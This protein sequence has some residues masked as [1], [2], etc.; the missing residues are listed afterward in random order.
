M[1]W[2]DGPADPQ[3]TGEK[4]AVIVRAQPLPRAG[5]PNAALVPI[6]PASGLLPIR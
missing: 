2:P 1:N 6:L 4:P 5:A 3:K